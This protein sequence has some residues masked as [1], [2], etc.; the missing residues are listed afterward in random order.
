MVLITESTELK[1]NSDKKPAPS[2]E[3][4]TPHGHEQF[5][6]NTTVAAV[7]HHQGKFLL[8]EEV[9]HH[10]NVLNQPAGHLEAQ[11]NLVDAMKRE[12]LEETGLA[13]DPDY[14]CGIYYY[15]REDIK[16]HFLR[17]CFVVELNEQLIGQPQDSEIL[18]NHWLDINQIKSK[19]HILRSP[20]V[21]E[22]IE[23]YLAGNKISLSQLKTNL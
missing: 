4:P 15:Y 5:K 23:D 20:M 2:V 8:V 11:E 14:I 1:S 22:C 6:P 9:E 13:L 12:V 3:S 7:I 16:L 10:K 17:F 21:L 19:Q 18:A